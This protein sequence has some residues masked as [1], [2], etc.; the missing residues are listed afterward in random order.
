MA[1]DLTAGNANTLDAL[2]IALND[3]LVSTLGWTQTKAAVTPDLDRDYYIYHSTG[4]STQE[5][6]YCGLTSYFKTDQICGLMFNGYTG[7]NA[8][9]DF[10]DQPGSAVMC[11]NVQCCAYRY[12]PYMPLHDHVMA[13]WFWGDKDMVT[14]VVGAT[15]GLYQAFYVGLCR[16]YALRTQDPYPM[17]VDGS[18]VIVSAGTSSVNCNV[19]NF[20]RPNECCHSPA[21][22]NVMFGYDEWLNYR[23][24][25]NTNTETH[26]LVWPCK[27][28]RA[29]R[30]YGNRYVLFPIVISNLGGD[31]GEFKWVFKVPGEGLQ[32]L[33]TVEIDGNE[34]IVFPDPGE[35]SNTQWWLAFRNYA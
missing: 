21:R 34:Y 19:R 25:A 4:E 32:V 11:P 7:Y 24:L 14:G 5:D 15:G 29:A 16:R 3:F 12:M 33:D 30:M 9:K 26:Q 1:F 28:L 23:Y 31:R 22:H 8:S 27:I 13:Y 6:I 35:P 17:I 20:G 2:V 10:M 18:G